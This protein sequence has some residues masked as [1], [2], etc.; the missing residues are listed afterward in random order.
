MVV[1]GAILRTAA[2]LIVVIMAALVMRAGAEAY[3]QCK[4]R[5]WELE[6]PAVRWR[7]VEDDPPRK[8]GNYIVTEQ[9]P[10]NIIPTKA[11]VGMRRYNGESF[12]PLYIG[13]RSVVVAWCDATPYRAEE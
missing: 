9:L 2:I 12:E 1:M 3:C 8:P 11:V 13:D 5:V 7:L 6:Q 10:A 4:R